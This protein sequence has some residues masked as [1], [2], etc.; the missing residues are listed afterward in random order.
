MSKTA[1]TD[2]DWAAI[3]LDAVRS[4]AQ[5]PSCLRMAAAALYIDRAALW[6]A[7]DRRLSN[8]AMALDGET[9]RVATGPFAG[10]LIGAIERLTYRESSIANARYVLMKLNGLAGEW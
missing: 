2:L 5:R 10:Y 7:R 1:Y 4:L 3:V 8:L 6:T 9:F